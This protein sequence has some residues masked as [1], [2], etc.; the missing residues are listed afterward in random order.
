MHRDA[1]E[2]GK[3]WVLFPQEMRE[4][5]CEMFSDFL[6]RFVQYHWDAAHEEFSVTREDLPIDPEYF[7]DFLRRSLCDTDTHGIRSEYSIDDYFME[8]CWVSHALEVAWKLDPSVPDDF[9]IWQGLANQCRDEGG[10]EEHAHAFA[11]AIAAVNESLH[12]IVDWAE[13][14]DDK[15]D[16]RMRSGNT[17]GLRL[18]GRSLSRNGF[19]KPATVSPNEADI[20]Q[21]LMKVK[22]KTSG[23]IV[24]QRLGESENAMNQAI[25]RLNPKLAGL[26]VEI[27]EFILTEIRK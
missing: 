26:K 4:C 8:Y 23:R 7:L 11:E 21:L 9:L 16:K 12:R 6:E 20:L 25:A 14:K 17:L 13:S 22:Q 15:I 18:D 3:Y 27:K 2:V 10:N 19:L 24:A 1:R 5:L